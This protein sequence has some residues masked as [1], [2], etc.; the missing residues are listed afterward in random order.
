MTRWIAIGTV[1]QTAMVVAGHFVATVALLF[2]PL[3]MGISLV[4]GLLW[5]RAEARGLGDGAKGGAIVGG[6]CAFIGVAISLA[7]GDVM[8]VIL[9]VGTVSSAVAGAVGGVVGAKL[10]PRAVVGA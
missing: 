4:V 7:L 8:A 3:G 1:L 6:T 5:A 9:L 10:R 2:A